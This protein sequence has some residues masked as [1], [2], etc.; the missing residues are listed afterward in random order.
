MDINVSQ[1]IEDKLAQMD[2]S[3]IITKKIEEV[4]EKVVLSAIVSE[5]DCYSFR[6]GIAKQVETSIN[7]IAADCGLSAY[8]GFIAERV[9]DIIRDLYT[10]DVAKKVQN[11]LTNTILKHY[12]SIKLSEIFDRYRKW[13]RDNTDADDQK[14]RER[15]TAELVCKEGTY[16]FTHVYCRFADGPMYEDADN[17]IEVRFLV[18]GSKSTDD[19]S[20]VYFDGHDISNTVCLGRL[21]E[22]EAFIANLYYN[23][24]PIVLDCEEIDSDDSYFDLYED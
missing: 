1:I 7:S 19:I 9:R 24:T 10:D 8:N 21:S 14:D 4:L 2:A 18:Y 12:D 23:K 3:G 11:A 20:K 13:V 16:G 5:I 15:F 17:K 22:F 6:S